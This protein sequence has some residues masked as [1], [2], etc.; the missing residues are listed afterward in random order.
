MQSQLIRKNPFVK[1]E[2]GNQYHILVYFPYL[3]RL[4]GLSRNF[5]SLTEL[6]NNIQEVIIWIKIKLN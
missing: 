5:I 4:Q 1:Y 2:F 3:D 6:A